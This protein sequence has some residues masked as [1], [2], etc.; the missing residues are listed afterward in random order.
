MAKLKGPLFSLGATQ[1]LG[2][3]L[4]FFGWKGL[5]V[6]REYVVPA[7]PKTDLQNKQRDKLTLAVRVVHGAMAADPPLAEKDIF[8]YALWA[9]VVQAATTWF[10]QAVRHMIDQQ[11][12][13]KWAMMFR[14]GSTTSV[15]EGLDVEVYSWETVADTGQFNYGTSK[16]A[17]IKS[18]GSTPAVHKHSASLS[19]LTP[20][21]KYYWQFEALTG[22]LAIGSKSGIYYGVPAK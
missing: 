16:T 2:K 10:N 3:S 13:A 12:L 1:Q 7:N 6:V 9:G 22:D 11:R 18:E 20:G 14:G 5:N 15:S 8:A 17:M 19:G 4:V 21:V